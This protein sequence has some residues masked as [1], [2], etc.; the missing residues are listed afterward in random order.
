M[1][2]K[3]LYRSGRITSRAWVVILAMLIFSALAIPVAMAQVPEQAQASAAHE[4]MGQIS[5]DVPGVA[6]PTRDCWIGP[7]GSG[8][9]ALE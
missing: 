4:G 9:L 7:A 3:I 2:A 1:I 6:P 5:D 8:G